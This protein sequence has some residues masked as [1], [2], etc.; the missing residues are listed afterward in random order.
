MLHSRFYP[1]AGDRSVSNQILTLQ[2]DHETMHV[3]FFTEQEG[4]HNSWKVC[5][6]PSRYNSD[7]YSFR[8]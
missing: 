4:V 1:D 3:C 6:F 7:L 8:R 5:I 2:M